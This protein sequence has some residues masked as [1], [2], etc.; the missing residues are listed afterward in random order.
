MKGNPL[1]AA[2][3]FVS[4]PLRG[5]KTDGEILARKVFE[6]CSFIDCKALG[7][8]WTRAGWPR[9]ALGPSPRFRGSN[10]NDSTFF[11]LQLQELVIERCSAVGVDFRGGVF[12]RGYSI[13]IFENTIEKAKFTRDEAL[14][15]PDSRDIELVD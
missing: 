5:L 4:K 11:D 14:S 8:D 6:E 15:L 1:S 3:E 12:T 2:D 7:I 9:V 10:L 13:D